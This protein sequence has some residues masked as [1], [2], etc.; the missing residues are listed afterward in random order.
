MVSETKK[1]PRQVQELAQSMLR[2]YGGKC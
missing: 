2:A 1:K